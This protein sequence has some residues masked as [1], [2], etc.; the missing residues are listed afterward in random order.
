MI[1]DFEFNQ[2]LLDMQQNLKIFASMLSYTEEDAEDLTQD[3]I[4]KAISNKEK[5]RD[6]QNIRAWVFT[7]MKNLFINSYR[8][9]GNYRKIILK[10][11]ESDNM[12]S[13]DKCKIEDTD[14]CVHIGELWDAVE[15]LDNKYR[16]PFVYHIKGYKYREISELMNLPI[17]TIKSRIYYARKSLTEDL[18]E[19]NC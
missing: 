13:W 14:S 10:A 4:I 5:F 18:V 7:I 19:L 9:N 11:S 6:K 8:R 2:Q 15:R 3:T 12:V 1:P 17:G 16:F